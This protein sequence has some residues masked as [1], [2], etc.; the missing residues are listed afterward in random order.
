MKLTEKRLAKSLAAFRKSQLKL[1]AAEEK[2]HKLQD[3][4]EDAADMVVSAENDKKQRREEW[5][6]ARIS[7]EKAR[8][9][10]YRRQTNALAKK[11]AIK[12]ENNI[13]DWLEAGEVRHWVLKPAWLSGDDPLADGHHS[14]DWEDTLWLVEFYA[15]HSPAHPDHANREFLVTSPHC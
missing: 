13:E 15:K 1:D 11:Y 6:V 8:I 7:C 9:A 14:N 12:I 3:L 10:R 2:V 5:Q 4:L